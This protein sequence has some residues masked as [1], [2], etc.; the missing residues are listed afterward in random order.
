S[1]ATDTRF[2]DAH[3]NPP[4]RNDCLLWFSH[5]WRKPSGAV[6]H[7]QESAAFKSGQTRQEVFCGLADS[8]WSGCDC[9]GS[10]FFGRLADLLLVDRHEL[11]DDGR[12]GRLSDG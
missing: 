12:G 7:H 3:E 10:A 11:A 2:R 9:R 1:V 5:G 6:Q 8:G 4:V